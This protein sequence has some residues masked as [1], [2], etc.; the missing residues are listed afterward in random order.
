MA[1]TMA[2]TTAVLIFALMTKE[3]GDT[4]DVTVGTGKSISYCSV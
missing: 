2:A 4:I 3:K 1:V